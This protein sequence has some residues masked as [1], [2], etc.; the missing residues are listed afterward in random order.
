MAVACRMSRADWL[1]S[2]SSAD[3]AAKSD[4]RSRPTGVAI[5]NPAFGESTSTSG[6]ASACR[7]RKPA[8]VR[9]ASETR[10]SRASARRLAA[11]PVDTASTTL[12]SAAARTSQ[13]CEGW[14]SQTPSSPGAASSSAN[15][16][17]GS[18]IAP[19][20]ASSLPLGDVT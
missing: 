14:C 2:N 12:M 6:V 18:A 9:N 4:A 15:P 8:A 7:A 10:K 20:H 3:A 13:K 5:T 1:W 16:A 17:S 11:S 19:A